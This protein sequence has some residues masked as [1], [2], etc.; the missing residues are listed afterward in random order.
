MAEKD[1]AVRFLSPQH[2]GIALFAVGVVLRVADQHGIAL[3]LG[4]VLDPL[5]NEREERV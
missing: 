3:A 4:G 5:E 2:Q 1:Q